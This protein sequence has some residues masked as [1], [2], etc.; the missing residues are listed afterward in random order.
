E[1][2]LALDQLLLEDERRAAVQRQ[3]E[4]TAHLDGVVHAAFQAPDAPGLL[5]DPDR[6]HQLLYPGLGAPAGP[7]PGPRPEI[8]HQRLLAAEHLA[9]RVH[10][11]AHAQDL[12]DGEL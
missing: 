11:L 3:H 5:V 8:E 1:P 7:G 12:G 4:P 2:D 9:P 6:A 10:E